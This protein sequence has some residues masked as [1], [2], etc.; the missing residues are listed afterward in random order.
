MS[1]LL[2]QVA[3]ARQEVLDE[4]RP[5]AVK[6]RRDRNLPTARERVKSLLDLD[7][8]QELGA[9]VQPERGNEFSRGLQ[10]PA[11]GIVT[12]TG[13]IDGR[14]VNVAAHDYTVQGGSSGM[15]GRRKLDR[16]MERSLDRGLPLVM[17]LEGGGHRIQDG[18]SSAHFAGAGPVFQT[19]S[20]MSGWVPSVA[21]ML[22]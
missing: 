20:R 18:M 14:A 4:G 10:A 13:R 1:D 17:M 3:A 16:L 6:K 11:D 19:M 7:S 22:G 15:I 2:S 8:F 5:D 9:L 21:L 12:G